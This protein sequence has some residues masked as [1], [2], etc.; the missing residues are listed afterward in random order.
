MM[1]EIERKAPP[2]V[3]I[4][5]GKGQTYPFS[6]ALFDSGFAKHLS[7]EDADGFRCV[8]PRS[9][10]VPIMEHDLYGEGLGVLVEW[11]KGEPAP[12]TQQFPPKDYHWLSGVPPGWNVRFILNWR[13]GKLEVFEVK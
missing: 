1:E 6:Q 3:E 2:R 8:N 4:Q 13:S 9:A 10:G 11:S 5:I 7:A 12:L